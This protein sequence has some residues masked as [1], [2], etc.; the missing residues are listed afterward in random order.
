MMSEISDLR[1][2]VIGELVAAGFELRGGQL[3]PPVGDGKEVAR[4]LHSTQRRSALAKAAEFIGDNE[5]DLI[6]SFADGYEIEPAK[7]EP[8]IVPVSNEREAALFK[9]ASLHWSVPVSQGY[10]R[11]TRFLIL[12]GFNGKLIGIFALGDPV[13]NLGAR[14]QV[15][16]WTQADRQERLYNCFDG[17]VLG[18]VEPYRQLIAGKLAAMCAVSD[19]VIELL[20]KKYSGKTTVIAQ[21][22]KASRPVLVTTTSALGRSSIYNRLTF[23]SE[24]LFIPVGFTA[25]FGHFQ[26]SDEVFE[27]LVELVRYN[28]DF[29]GAAYG[30]GP[31][32][33]IRTIRQALAELGLSGDLLK[34]GIQRE[35]Y[36]A[37]LAT[38]YAAYLRGDS[39][40]VRAISRPL[41]DLAEYWRERWAIPRSERR[42]EW[43]EFK[44]EQMKLSPQLPRVA[45]RQRL[46]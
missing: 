8:R 42:P 38:N 4:E 20:E 32:Y 9:F 29:R 11:R 35:V 17:Y 44:R 19:E 37:P 15:I 34:H 40:V 25:G 45:I 23:R 21:A 27:E 36:L 13:F 3:I 24:R 33:K 28:D 14:D 22:V 18:A 31:N 1:R 43:A 2:R 39:T 12:D 7:I 5:S 30:K 41:A 46:F 16:G 10:G 6:S 26:F